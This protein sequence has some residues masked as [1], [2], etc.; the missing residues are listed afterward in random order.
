WGTDDRSWLMYWGE[1]AA[2]NSCVDKNDPV[3]KSL[4]Q[5]V[6]R[7][8]PHEGNGKD[9]TSIYA[10]A[11][12]IDS[13]D[14]ATSDAVYDWVRTRQVQHPNRLIMA[15]K[16]SSSK[17]DPEIFT[18]PKLHSIDHRRHDKKTKAQRQGVKVYLVGTNKAKDWL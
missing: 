7:A 17:Q 2:S 4:D 9:E 5:V 16:G 1:I 15:V 18:Q 10:S 11:I 14:G 13:S 12:S 3:W 6:F 8:F